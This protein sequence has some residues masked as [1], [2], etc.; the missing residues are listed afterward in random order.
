[1][2]FIKSKQKK[3]SV[4]LTLV[5]AAPMDL[6]PSTLL[7]L[8]E[9]AELRDKPPS[10]N[11][12]ATDHIDQSLAKELRST[13]MPS[14]L[15][16]DASI[17][18]LWFLEDKT[19]LKAFLPAY[20]IGT[21]I[22]VSTETGY[23]PS[24]VIPQW[25]YRYLKMGAGGHSEE[26]GNLAPPNALYFLWLGDFP[27]VG[28]L[29]EHEIQEKVKT[30]PQ[31]MNPLG[32]ASHRL[33]Y[34]QA[35]DYIQNYVANPASHVGQFVLYQPGNRA[36][37]MWHTVNAIDTSV[38]ANPLVVL[39]DG[40]QTL[41]IGKDQWKHLRWIGPPPTQ[42]ADGVSSPYWDVIFDAQVAYLLYQIK[43]ATDRMASLKTN[44]Q[45]LRARIDDLEREGMTT[46]RR[47]YKAASANPLERAKHQLY[48]NISEERSLQTERFGYVQDLAKLDRT[49][50]PPH[51]Q[52][53]INQAIQLRFQL[54]MIEDGIGEAFNLN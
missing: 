28:Y 51:V 49:A 54:N 15:D 52:H 23:W 3:T 46:D 31:T 19:Q 42:E 40:N 35:D 18:T 43:Y 48:A 47:L 53:L 10:V 37:R 44:I 22:Y 4:L 29:N 36:T 9:R 13:T 30:T 27:T 25:F 14:D 12:H 50:V 41:S 38:T 6:N 34:A 33:A 26:I 11:A 21:L 8:L 16:E 2:H 24:I 39:N 20:P 1:M 17:D 32:T 7:E 5:G 45:R